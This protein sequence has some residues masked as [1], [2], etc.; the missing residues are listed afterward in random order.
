[1]DSNILEEQLLHRLTLMDEKSHITPII[2]NQVRSVTLT[3]ILRLYQ[4]IHDEVP[5][6][7]KNLTVPGKQSSRF[8]MRNYIYRGKKYVARATT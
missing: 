1:M 3:I 4:D 8:I 5:V 7:L 6:L 2:T